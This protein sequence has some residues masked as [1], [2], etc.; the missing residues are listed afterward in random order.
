[1]RE[2][3]S[4][5]EAGRPVVL[6]VSG[7]AGVGKTRLLTE[8]AAEAAQ[9]GFTILSGRCAELAETVPYLPLADAL[10]SASG[11]RLADALATR[12]VL[13]R[14]L[15]DREITRQPGDLP[16]LAQQQLFGAVVGMLTELAD[17]QPV[18]LMLEDLHWADRSTRDLVTFLSRVLRHERIALALSY[19]TDD[20]H[21]A[22]PLRPVVGELLRLPSVTAIDV[23]PLEPEA[24]A[25]HLASL[26]AGLHDGAAIHRVVERAEGN[27]YFAEELLASSS[28]GN[29]LPTGLADLLVA[30]TVDLSPAAQ[31]VLRV[32]AVT[33]RRIDDELVMSATALPT[34]DYEEAVREAVAHQLLVPDGSKGLAF[35]H[36][37]LREAIYNDLLPGERSRLHA[38]FAELLAD[39]ADSAAE[40]AIH[41]LASH[42][43]PG[44]FSASVAAAEDAWRLAA[45]AE[46]H[47]LFDQAL[48]LWERVPEPEKLA[49]M[50]RGKL[51]FKSALSAADS[52]QVSSAVKQLRRLRD[53]LRDRPEQ[54]L[55]LLCRVQE[56]LAYF[57]HDIDE[58]AEAIASANAAVDVLPA[59]PPTWERAQALAT[60]AKTL[61]SFTDTG[62]ARARAIEAEAAAQAARAPWLEADALATLSSLSERAGHIAD[63]K[64]TAARALELASSS[65]M[66]GVELRVRTLLARIEL[67]SGDLAAAG[68]TAHLGVERAIQTGL[69]MAPYG[70]DLQYLHYLAHYNDGNWDHAQE[71]SDGFPVQV[72][73][74]SE[75]RLSAMALFI[76]VA[77]GSSR[78]AERRAWLEPYMAVDSLAEYI[79]EGLFA[80]DAYWSGDL[81]GALTAVKATIG[82]ATTWGGDEYGPQVIRPAALGIAALADQARLARAAGQSVGGIIDEAAELADVAR[83]SLHSRRRVADSIGVDGRGWL[84]R[85]EAEMRR[86]A[87]DNAPDNWRAVVDA[88]GPGFRYEV[89]RSQWRLAEALAEAGDRDE[90]QHQWQ[91]AA[92]AADKLGAT[93]LRAALADLGRRARLGPS[94]RAVAGSPL[95][96][97]TSRELEVLQE[98]ASGRSNREIASELFISGKTVSVHVSNILAKLG[99]SSRTEAAAIAHDNGIRTNSVSRA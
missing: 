74:I 16:G 94:S 78:V 12:P 33:G 73:S 51:A 45:P 35:R 38:R 31:Q 40:L 97:L 44:A 7:D 96:V 24:M 37:L 81:A 55:A 56:R 54:D 79:A 88:F 11:S 62:P 42:D 63:A 70:T 27:P 75:A 60:H 93:R 59:D 41:S 64:A 21:R 14:L 32:A 72:T 46:A 8:L 43:I 17:A 95:S 28:A 83:L 80:E 92:T 39:R 23:G 29:D 58:D 19:R 30:R 89:A 57:L 52:G 67:E 47:R 4:D 53:V 2:L 49:G 22:H 13:T 48:S 86:A 99:A 50:G 26:A 1:M 61:L 15:P 91:L 98:L 34:A 77:R 90:A 66:A 76:D 69:S 5:A 6:L 10:R 65:D 85:A 9:R 71:I 3:L 68:T 36:A 25:L 20:M 82:A 18:L 84:A 87:D